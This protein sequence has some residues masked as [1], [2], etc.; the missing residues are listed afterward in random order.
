M[1]WFIEYANLRLLARW[2]SLLTLIIGVVL[3]AMIGA[4]AILYTHAIAQIGMVET[5]NS[6]RAGLAHIAIRLGLV[7]AESADLAADWQNLDVG[8][9]GIFA[10]YQQQGWGR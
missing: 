8:V 7:P 1:L 6:D 4:N 9:A 10:S 2:R 5:L 3:A